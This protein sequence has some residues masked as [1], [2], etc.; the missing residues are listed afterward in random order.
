MHILPVH[1]LH[2]R[3]EDNR[4]YCTLLHLINSFRSDG[5]QIVMS[6]VDMHYIIL[7]L[8]T[9][10]DVLRNNTARRERQI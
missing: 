9:T 8:E 5:R 4:C 10:A 3:A 1:R 6:K 2:V 7:D